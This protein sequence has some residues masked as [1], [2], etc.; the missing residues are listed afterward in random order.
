[1]SLETDKSETITSR[2]AYL[3]MYYFVRAYWERGGKLD[4]NVTLL[5]N[6][7]GPTQNPHQERGIWTNDPAFWD[8]WLAAVERAQR[9]GLPPEL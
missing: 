1:M 7:L 9:E 8:D 5:L 4:G 3:A 6:A 2:D